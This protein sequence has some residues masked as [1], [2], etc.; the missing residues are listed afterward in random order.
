MN[1]S[2]LPKFT[3][4]LFIFIF[5]QT[6]TIIPSSVT[7]E[8]PVIIYSHGSLCNKWIPSLFHRT[9]E[10]SNILCSNAFI[11]GPMK[12]FNYQDYIIPFLSCMGQDDDIKR[13]HEA[14][15]DHKQVILIG[16]SRGAAA[17][18]NYLGIYQPTNIIGAVIEST[19]DIYEYV[20][21]KMLSAVYITNKETQ[22]KLLPY[23]YKNYLIEII[24]QWRYLSNG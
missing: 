3:L 9:I 23:I 2:R 20:F 15:K 1:L 12:T 16:S 5:I 11:L 8:E 18:I 7:E 13:L 21:D 19:F 6:G 14:C 10:R 4:S 22:K 17:I 24:H